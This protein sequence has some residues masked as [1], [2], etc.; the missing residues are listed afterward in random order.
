MASAALGLA[1]ADRACEVSAVDV[2]RKRALLLASDLPSF[3][4]GVLGDG[5]ALVRT[6]RKD[7]FD[8]AVTRLGAP[9]ADEVYGFVPALAVGGVE[10]PAALERTKAQEHLSTLLQL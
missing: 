2:R 9:N 3:V 1:D 10:E 6:L 5:A 7:L 4:E 8:G